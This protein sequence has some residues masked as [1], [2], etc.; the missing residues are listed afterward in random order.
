MTT[1]NRRTERPETDC[2][3][4]EPSP[5]IDYSGGFANRDKEGFHYGVIK[6]YNLASWIWDEVQGEYDIYCPQCGELVD[7]S[8][9]V[10]CEKCSHCGSSHPDYQFSDE[11]RIQYIQDKEDTPEETYAVVDSDGDFFVMKSP[12]YTRSMYCSPC[13]PG[14]GD[15]M[16]PCP[17]GPRT[18]C[19]GP[20]WLAEHFEG[21]LPYPI[22]R[23]DTN[24]LVQA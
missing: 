16:N 6:C 4:K 10:D 9:P 17:N 11:P 2:P 12:Y 8:Q 19:L 22:Y 1:K 15:L 14:A 21:R 24:E 3:T 5:G 20:E 7:E 23:K 18:L 13:A